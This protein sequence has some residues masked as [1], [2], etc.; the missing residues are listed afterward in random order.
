[1]NPETKSSGKSVLGVGALAV[2]ACA[3]CCIGPVLAFLG[4]LGVL[5][6]L[7]ALWVPA[8]AAVTV[9]ALA[10]MAWVLHRRRRAAVCSTGQGPVDL[11]MPTSPPGEPAGRVLPQ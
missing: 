6:A 10:G 7:G 3:A 1:M 11:G 8:L 5:S 4:G 9:L 2:L